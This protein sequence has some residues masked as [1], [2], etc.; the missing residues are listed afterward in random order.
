MTGRVV[1][2]GSLNVDLALTCD[3]IPAPGETVLATAARRSAGGKGAN[4][5][6]A[7]AR[8][9]GASTSIVGAVGDDPDGHYLLDQLGRAG[10][11]TERV[12]VVAGQ[13]S[14]LALITVDRAGE[15]AIVVA[16]GANAALAIDAPDREL[17]HT[18]D[19]VLAQLETPQQLV[20]EA[21]RSRRSGVPFILNAAP[22]A[23][24]TDELAREVDVLVVN[25]HEARSVAGTNDLDEAIQLLV[26]RFPVLLVTLGAGGSELHRADLPVIRARALTVPVVDTTA[27][28][29]TYCGVLAAGLAAGRP[30]ERAMPIAGAAASLTVQRSGAQDSIPTRAEVEALQP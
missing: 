14:G 22:A 7:A 10:V 29:D 16:P 3:T 25:E 26:A 17:L 6:V 12:A 19:V 11:G 27:A 5:A 18:A 28:G 9:G 13:S 4:Q 8:A 21:A 20:A 23:P 1:V 30:V 15:N 2:V 24:L